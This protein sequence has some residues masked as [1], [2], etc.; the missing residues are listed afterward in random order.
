MGK[1]E[2]RLKAYC[3]RPTFSKKYIDKKTITIS[4][5]VSS[6]NLELTQ[7]V[8][9]SNIWPDKVSYDISMPRKVY[10]PGKS[11][12][13]TFDLLPI[14]S[15]LTV[16]SISCIMKEY[17]TCS[18]LEQRKTTSRMI[19]HVQDNHITFQP[20]S[21]HWVKTELLYI[22]PIE[23]NHVN[24]DMSSELI[25]VKHKIKFTV[26]LQN[27]DGHISGIFSY[28]LYKTNDGLTCIV[29]VK[30]SNSCSDSSDGSRRRR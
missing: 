28:K 4:R 29:R 25:Q 1:V 7:S 26:S 14:A 17:T 9:I 27:K 19:H 8:L 18:T 21:G 2:Y 20:S 3:D 6:S 15:H 23:T 5:Q 12:P 22:P 11:I 24:F 16:K 30:S 10:S 13:L